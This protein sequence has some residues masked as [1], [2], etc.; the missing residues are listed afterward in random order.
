MRRDGHDPERGPEEI[1]KEHRLHRGEISV[2]GDE[3]SE[4]G[5]QNKIN[6]P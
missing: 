6:N 5:L 1:G 4:T 2:K 3:L